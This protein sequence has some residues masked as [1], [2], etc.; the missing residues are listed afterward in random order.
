MTELRVGLSKR[1]EYVVKK[2]DSPRF[3]S[4]KG[5]GV[6]STPR[7][8]ALMETTAKNLLDE[9]LDPSYTS[10]GYHI[11]VYHKAPAPVG[12]RIVFIATVKEIRGR[13]VVF[14]VRCMLGDTIIGE[15]IHERFIIPWEK[16]MEKVSML[17]RLYKY[18]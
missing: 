16:F 7:M 12:A 14:E 10:V 4:E 9:T 5:I 11:D 6:L 17:R 8:I 3:L 13:R 1:L 15:G 18:G 2:D